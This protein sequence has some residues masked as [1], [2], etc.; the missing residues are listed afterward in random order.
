VA[1]YTVYGAADDAWRVLSRGTT[2]GYTKLDRFT[3]SPVRRVKV[4]VDDAIVAAEPITV[5]LYGAE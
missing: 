3:P 1:K 5:R 2:I 4:A